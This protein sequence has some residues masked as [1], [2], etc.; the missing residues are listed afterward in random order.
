MRIIGKGILVLPGDVIAFGYLLG[1]QS[2][3]PI[4]VF[5]AF[6]HHIVIWRGAV[7][8][9]GNIA[10]TLRSTGYDAVGHSSLYFG[11]RHGN[12]LNSGGTITVHRY[13]W[14]IFY[15]QPH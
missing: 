3:S 7:S 5:M 10:H 12:G 11:G 2:H 6:F 8:P 1:R 14:D 15:V 13:S 9:H 4:I